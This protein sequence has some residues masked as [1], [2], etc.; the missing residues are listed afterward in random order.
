MT[1]PPAP[2]RA[3]VTVS[4]L[5]VAP[6]DVAGLRGTLSMTRRTSYVRETIAATIMSASMQP[7]AFADGREFQGTWEGYG[8]VT[9]CDGDCWFLSAGSGVTVTLRLS[10]AGREVTGELLDIPVTGVA[11]ASALTLAGTLTRP[12][13]EDIGIYLRRLEAF[14]ASTDGLGRLTGRFR[15]LQ[16]AVKDERFENVRIA[17][18]VTI[19][20]LS[21][22]RR[23]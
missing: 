13:P 4:S 14:D 18:T 15:F 8:M 11:S 21:V 7:F 9:G 17:G 5:R 12:E 10:Q 2:P 23:P 19:E 16:R 3:L 6:D 1:V 20:L 22:V